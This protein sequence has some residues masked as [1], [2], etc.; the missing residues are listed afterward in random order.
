MLDNSRKHIYDYL[1]DLFK[2]KPTNNVYD[3]QEP[4]ELTKSD[5]K[6]GFIVTSVGGIY[7][8]SEFSGQAYGQVRCYVEAFIPPRSRGRLDSDKYE[9]FETAL[10]D[11]I[12][13]AIANDDST[14]KYHILDGSLLSSDTDSAVLGDNLFFTFIKT[15][16]L[17]IDVQ[18]E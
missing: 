18:D 4:Q 12:N 2:G 16:I 14:K 7:D 3:R 5:L 6:D 15:F 9:A 11:V 8:A 1:Y 13:E 10:T 17:H